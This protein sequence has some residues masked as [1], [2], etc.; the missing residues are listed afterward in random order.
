MQFEN[1]A[2]EWL[3][4][5]KKYWKESTEAHYR[6]ELYSDI[7]PNLGEMEVENITEETIQNIVC[8]WQTEHRKSGKVIKKSTISNL[9]MLIRQV[10][11]YGNKKGITMRIKLKYILMKNKK[12]LKMQSF[13][14]CLLSP[15]VYF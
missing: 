4:V 6:Y 10:I 3:D 5:K 1:L 11:K 2:L 7:L 15:L 13:Q 14:N 8:K 12:K 9:V